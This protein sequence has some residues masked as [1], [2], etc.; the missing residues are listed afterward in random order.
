LQ[1]LSN[2]LLNLL[3]GNAVSASSVATGPLDACKMILFTNAISP[4]PATLLADL[5]QPTYTGYTPQAVVWSTVFTLPNG[6]Y[7]VQGTG[8]EWQMGDGA[9]PTTV[10][11]MALTD[12]AGS[13]LLLTEVFNTPRQLVLATDAIIVL[14]QFANQGQGAG[15]SSVLPWVA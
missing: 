5:T 12:S 11:G 2:Y 3:T 4:T 1:I 15:K 10:I 9:L 14:P 6:N 7:C 8:L 13:H